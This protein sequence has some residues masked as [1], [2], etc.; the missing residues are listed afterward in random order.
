MSRFKSIAYAVKVREGLY[1][2]VF[3]PNMP[4]VCLK[5]LKFWIE[6]KEFETMTILAFEKRYK[7]DCVW[8]EFI[9]GNHRWSGYRIDGLK[10]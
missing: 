1:Q 7:V 5:E 6:Q 3:H 2:L 8:T 9:V 4:A 10:F